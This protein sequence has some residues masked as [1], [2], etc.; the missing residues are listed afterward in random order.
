MDFTPFVARHLRIVAS[1]REIV[2]FFRFS[3]VVSLDLR[4]VVS[5]AVSLGT[6]L[7]SMGLFGTARNIYSLSQL[8]PDKIFYFLFF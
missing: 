6:P 8:K 1:S 2:F 7:R 5:S 4:R 3:L